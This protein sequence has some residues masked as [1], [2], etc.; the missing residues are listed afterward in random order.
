MQPSSASR[1]RRAL[2]ALLTTGASLV[3]ATPARAALPIA[4]DQTVTITVDGVPRT[5]L[6]HVPPGPATPD[7]PLLVVFH[8]RGETAAMTASTTD[9]EQVADRTDEVVAFLQGYDD[10]WNPQ[11]GPYWTG[12]PDDVAFVLAAIA[13][14]ES[15]VAFDHA[16][17]VAV[18]FSF[19][20]L[21]SQDLGCRL[22]GTF[23][24]IVPVEGELPSAL[25]VR[26]APSRPLPVYEVHGTADPTIPYGGG[27]FGTKRSGFHLLSAPSSAARW[28]QLDGC[29]SAPSVEWVAPTVE[30]TSYRHCRNHASV[31]LRTLV[32]GVHD[33]GSDIGWVVHQALPAP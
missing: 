20:A 5:L 13:R 16:R 31:T 24:M 14:L 6:L 2:L 1:A 12:K 18:G 3:V 26:C 17:I 32:G 19:G 25:S 22:A 29:A 9:F 27:L 15:L 28:A 7:R 30:L 11:V 10:S 33:W 8:G 21:L 4:G 23:A